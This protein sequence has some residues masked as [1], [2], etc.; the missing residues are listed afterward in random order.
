ML[1]EKKCFDCR[2]SSYKVEFYMNKERTKYDGKRCRTCQMFYRYKLK[3]KNLE[4]K[5]CKQCNSSSNDVYFK[6]TY[7]NKNFLSIC[8]KCCEK[9]QI[10][11][12]ICKICKSSSFDKKFRIK[13]YR[14]LETYTPICKDCEEKY[15]YKRDI[16]KKYNIKEKFCK[17]CKVSCNDTMFKHYKLNKTFILQNYCKKCSEEH[18]IKIVKKCVKCNKTTN[19]TFFSIRKDTGEYD[20]KCRN[21]YN[22]KYSINVNWKRKFNGVI[23][24]IKNE[25]TCFIKN[26]KNFN[27]VLKELHTYNNYWKK[28]FNKVI[29]QLITKFNFKERKRRNREN[30]RK[31]NHEKIKSRRHSLE[32]RLN[33]IKNSALKRNIKWRLSDHDSKEILKKDCYYCGYASVEFKE[34]NCIGRKDNNIDYEI[35]NCV[36][37]CKYCIF[38]KKKLNSEKFIKICKHIS[39]YN[40]NGNFGYY[41]ECFGDSIHVKYYKYI[42]NC[43]NRNR[44]FN[45]CQ[46]NFKKITKKDCYICGKKYKKDIHMNGIDRVENNIREYTVENCKPCCKTCNFLKWNY[47]HNFILNQC[48]KISLHV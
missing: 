31:N 3:T 2:K 13:I 43:K 8:Q 29:N 30:Y 21:C 6:T 9:Q 26:R 42:K 10:K 33:G 45:I 37:C 19:E 35:N 4:E 15:N 14:K 25:N 23:N 22:L 44:I 28:Q 20:T 5:I 27:K 46:E 39:T 7:G 36:S 11:E 17:T 47:S 48:Y 12:K 34:L 32:M 41:P 40:N 24:Q 16:I 18:D 1:K 38:M